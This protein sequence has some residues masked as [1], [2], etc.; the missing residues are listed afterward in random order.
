MITVPLLGLMNVRTYI[1]F[2]DCGHNS[3]TPSKTLNYMI[4]S[5]LG[6]PVFTPFCWTYNH[7]NHHLTSGNIE[8]KLE[9][10]QNETAH[11]TFK[12]YKEMGYKR[13]LYRTIMHPSV[14]FT[15]ISSVKFFIANRG[16]E[17][18]YKYNN[19]P[20][21]QSINLILF[22]TIVNNIGMFLL[23]IYMNQYGIFYHYL[24][25]V[26]CMS[27]IG[28]LFFHNQHTFNP[29]YVVSD[30]KWNKKE[31]GLIVISFIQIPKYLK[32]FTSG[33]EYHHLHHMNA[34]IPGYNLHMLHDELIKNTNELDNITTL[35]MN[36]CYH[37]LWLSLYDE[38]NNKYIT[39]KEAEKIK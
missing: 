30:E 26:V 13:Y 33:I 32:F 27:S 29:P 3:Y 28:F 11:Y 16:S 4:G 22:D 6:I 21:Q 14:F 23:L 9:H 37:N 20:Y 39:F 10:L 7:H 1:V 35:S 2:H 5:I 34:S 15:L 12:E 31:S 25:S 18:L 8:N 19:H 17:L 38:D 36:D 24:C